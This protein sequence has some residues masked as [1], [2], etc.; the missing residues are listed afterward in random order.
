[1]TVGLRTQAR[2]RMQQRD[3]G[4]EALVD[5]DNSER[6]RLQRTPRLRGR[7]HDIEELF[8]LRPRDVQPQRDEPPKSASRSPG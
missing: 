3:S 5:L 7:D 1:M 6:Q 8:Q 4:V 2:A